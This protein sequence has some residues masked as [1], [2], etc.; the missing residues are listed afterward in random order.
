M[1]PKVI[2]FLLYIIS[3]YGGLHRNAL[4]SNSGGNPYMLS[5]GEGS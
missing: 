2:A 4:L 1:G 3:P 5:E